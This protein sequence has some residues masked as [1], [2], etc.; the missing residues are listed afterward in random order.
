MGDAERILPGTIRSLLGKGEQC[1]NGEAIMKERESVWR[2]EK[3]LYLPVI[4][5]ILCTGMFAGVLSAA[6]TQITDQIHNTPFDSAYSDRITI[7]E[8]PAGPTALDQS[9]SPDGRYAFAVI[10]ANF[11]HERPWDTQIMVVTDQ[12]NR[13]YITLKD[14]VNIPPKIKWINGNLIYV[15]V[16][17]S[18]IRGTVMI[19]HVDK[20]QW[21]YR[22]M[23]HRVY[24]KAGN[25]T[26]LSP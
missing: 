18:K 1:R 3:L 7:H 22:E 6:N 5:G 25:K 14:H 10:R 9:I 11:R 2:R 19:Y 24:R 17:W 13:T 23:V 12:E 16:W 15:D 8:G 21:I 4:L 26:V 20:K